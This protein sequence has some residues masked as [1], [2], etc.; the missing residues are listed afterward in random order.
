MNNSFSPFYADSIV[1][2]NLILS[3]TSI[4]QKVKGSFSWIRIF[5]SSLEG[6]SFSV[7]SDF[8]LL[9]TLEHKINDRCLAT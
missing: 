9:E 5:I 7:G 1:H 3:R 8:K 2:K 6:H 4:S